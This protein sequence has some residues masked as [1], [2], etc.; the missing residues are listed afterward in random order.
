M[1]KRKSPVS[2]CQLHELQYVLNAGEVKKNTFVC[3]KINRDGTFVIT[4]YNAVRAFAPSNLLKG[5]SLNLIY[6]N[7][8]KSLIQIFPV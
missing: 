4:N 2:G 1:P 8:P 5:L 7:D 3:W 6:W